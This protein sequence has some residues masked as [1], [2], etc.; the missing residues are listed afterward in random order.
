MSRQVRMARQ[1]VGRITLQFLLDPERIPLLAQFETIEA[2]VLRS[3]EILSGS[4]FLF[5]WDCLGRGR[6]SRHLYL[7][8]RVAIWKCKVAAYNCSLGIDDGC[9][10][11]LNTRYCALVVQHLDRHLSQCAIG[12]QDEQFGSL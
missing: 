11:R 7:P 2:G 12:F 3:H 9:I 5:D 4:L 8:L 1:S 6:S 10:C